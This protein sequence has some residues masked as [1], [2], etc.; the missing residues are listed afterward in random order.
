MIQT[1]V[2][3]SDVEAFATAMQATLA[4]KSEDEDTEM[5]DDER[6]DGE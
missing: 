4:K 3:S 2:F 1:Y 6:K 5:K